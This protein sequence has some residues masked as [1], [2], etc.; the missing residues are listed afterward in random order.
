MF[1][2]RRMEWDGPAASCVTMINIGDITGER[3]RKRRFRTLVVKESTRKGKFLKC[4]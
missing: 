2:I 1:K 3:E 4:W